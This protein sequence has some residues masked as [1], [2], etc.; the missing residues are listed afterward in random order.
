MFV[1]LPSMLIILIFSHN[2]SIFLPSC[3]KNS[4]KMS[5]NQIL[6]G[7][8]LLWKTKTTLKIVFQKFLRIYYHN[9]SNHDKSID[10]Y[11]ISEFLLSIFLHCLSPTVS[12]GLCRTQA[13]GTFV[14]WGWAPC[15]GRMDNSNR[16]ICTTHCAV[17]KCNPIGKWSSSWAELYWYPHSL[18]LTSETCCVRRS[19]TKHPGCPVWTGLLLGP[20]WLLWFSQDKREASIWKILSSNNLRKFLLCGSYRFLPYFWAYLFIM[21]HLFRKTTCLKIICLTEGLWWTKIKI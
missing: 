9:V 7:K 10:I 6:L 11:K 17:A 15:P 8:P 19:P 13:L 12:S 21:L 2:T 5:C 18:C 20:A 1:P 4:C 16:G 3:C 14:L